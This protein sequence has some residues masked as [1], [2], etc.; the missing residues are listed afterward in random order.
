MFKHHTFIYSK[1][2]K[3]CSPNL[4]FCLN[5][6]T[7]NGVHVNWSLMVVN[8][9]IDAVRML[10]ASDKMWVHVCE[11]DLL[12][13]PHR[14]SCWHGL[15]SMEQRPNATLLQLRLLQSWCFGQP[16]KGVEEGQCHIDHHH[17]CFNCGV[18]DRV[19]CLQG[20]QNRRDLQQIQAGLHL[21]IF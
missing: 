18:F 11:P 7:K 20:R 16:Q 2:L 6:K 17:H 12:D 14:R 8:N 4:Y 21:M 1:R 13:K 15:P 10:Q 19:L 3:N 5:L 9:V